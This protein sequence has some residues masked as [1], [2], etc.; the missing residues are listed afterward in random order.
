[1]KLFKRSF[2]VLLFSFL[3]LG[4]LYAGVLIEPS[5]GYT[6]GV[7]DKNEEI[8]GIDIKY[9]YSGPA[10]GGKIGGTF[11]GF[12]V[13]FEYDLGNYEMELDP[14]PAGLELPKYD[15]TNMGVFAGFS[16][17]VLFRVWATY[18]FKSS[19]EPSV[20]DSYNGKGYSL[21]VGFR[22]I[23]IPLPFVSLCFNLEYRQITLDESESAAGVKGTVDYNI[24]EFLV[25]VSVPIDI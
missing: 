6:L 2:M 25:S 3:L 1:M 18:F 16:A 4:N 24:S 7:F 19:F 17:P 12:Q 22:P 14:K 9:A 23:P 21:G 15:V 10:Y 5:L 20:G 13:G 8:S 11:L